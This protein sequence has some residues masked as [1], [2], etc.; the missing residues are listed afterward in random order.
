MKQHFFLLAILLVGWSSCTSQTESKAQ[1]IGYQDL[2]VA[3]FKAKMA[4]PGIVVLDVR[5]PEETAEGKIER[6][7]EIDFESQNFEAEIDKL[8]KNKTYL[9]Y[10]RSGG[11]SSQA[12]KLMAGKGLK[13]IYNLTGGYLAWTK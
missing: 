6:A 1:A 5:T 13:N 12:C 3:E 7:V 8:D 2:N 9:V 4:E 11:R 10:C